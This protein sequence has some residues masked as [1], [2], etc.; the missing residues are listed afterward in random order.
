MAKFIEFRHCDYA[1]VHLCIFLVIEH[2]LLAHIRSLNSSINLAE[3]SS[4]IGLSIW[5]NRWGLYHV[6]STKCRY[7]FLLTDPPFAYVCVDLPRV[8]YFFDCCLVSRSDWGWITP[9]VPSNLPNDCICDQYWVIV[10]P[11]CGC[12]LISEWYFKWKSL[13]H[14]ICQWVP[15]FRALPISNGPTSY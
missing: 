14:V 15:R 8:N 10:A 6:H 2:C 1:P 12:S 13:S 11:S 7:A 5:G 3:H 9:N 4:L